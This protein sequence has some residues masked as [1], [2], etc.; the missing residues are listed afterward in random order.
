MADEIAV[1]RLEG[2]GVLRR[3][4][5]HG[6]AELREVDLAGK[7][8]RDLDAV[9]LVAVERRAEIEDRPRLRAAQHD[10]RQV[11]PASVGELE[12]AQ[13]RLGA[14]AACDLDAVEA[15]R[16]IASGF[17]LR[18]AVLPNDVSC[19]QLSSRGIAA[20]LAQ[21]A[22]RQR[23]L[24]AGDDAPRDIGQQAELAAVDA[25][26]QLVVDRDRLRREARHHAPA[27]R[28]QAQQHAAAVDG[29]RPLLDMAAARQALHR[30][31]DEGARDHEMPRHH[32]DADAALVLKLRDR[33]EHAVFRLAH[34]E[35]LRKV[36]A[37]RLELLRHRHEI[38][39]HLAEHARRSR[40]RAAP[41]ATS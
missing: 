4:D 41:R 14:L 13:P 36:R 6:A 37:Q 39:E 1:L 30:H 29:A 18:H 15:E 25:A 34:P 31:G 2:E 33:Q 11:D 3:H 17:A 22:H 21:P 28:R 23:P 9:D 8:R 32:I 10:D 16:L 12:R 27:L 26:E 7:A 38:A 5:E 19:P 35:A 24:A 40:R 20:E